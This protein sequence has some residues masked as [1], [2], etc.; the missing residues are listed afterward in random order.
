MLDARSL[1]WV[2]AL[3]VRR[4]PVPARGV[5]GLD[6]LGFA[7]KRAFPPFHRRG[8]QPSLGTQGGR[9]PPL[10]RRKFQTG[11]RGQERLAE[12]PTTSGGLTELPRA[13]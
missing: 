6:P 4:S 9:D 10:P 13:R 2:R 8:R 7:A 3:E 1:R 11:C 12:R 5:D